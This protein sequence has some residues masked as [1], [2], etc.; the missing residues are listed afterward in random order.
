[1]LNIVVE[2]VKLTVV[3]LGSHIHIYRMENKMTTIV[4]NTF[5]M[6]GLNGIAN[7]FKRLGA[8]TKRHRN[9]RR[10]INELSRLTTHELNDIGIARGD[11][12]YIAHQSYPKAAGGELVEVNRNLK[13]WV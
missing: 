7:F 10:T 1:M 6:V 4:A 5:E 11:I 13:G 3:R 8:E 9:I 2:R 12:W